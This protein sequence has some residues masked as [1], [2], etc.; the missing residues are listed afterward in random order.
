MMTRSSRANAWV[1]EV[2][3]GITRDRRMDTRRPSGIAWNRW[4]MFP[5]RFSI[6]TALRFLYLYHDIIGK[7][8]GSYVRLRNVITDEALEDFPSSVAYSA[9]G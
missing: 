4:R 8:D 6:C 7:A 2:G 3:H 5:H 1:V 9:T